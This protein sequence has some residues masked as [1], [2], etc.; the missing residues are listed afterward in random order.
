MES[1]PETQENFL[2]VDM[3]FNLIGEG[4]TPRIVLMRGFLLSPAALSASTDEIY[5][6]SSLRAS[7]SCKQAI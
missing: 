1:V 7:K 4:L 3:I 6:F 5:D 2:N